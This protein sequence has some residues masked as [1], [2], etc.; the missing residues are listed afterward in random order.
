LLLLPNLPLTP[1]GKL[2]RKALPA[3]DASQLQ[4]DYRA[5]QTETEQCLARIWAEV[6]QVP[7]VGLDDHFFELGGHSLLAA[8]VI[9]RIKTQLG[10]VLPL[11]SLFE[12][13]L[14]TDLAAL[15]AQQAGG[16]TDDDWSDM[17]QFMNAL[18]GEEV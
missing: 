16:A 11:R 7:R 5:P 4:G 3:P 15:L 17:D 13:P 18:E 10:V 12:K 6:L 14:L 2:D 9:A 1:S 8:Q